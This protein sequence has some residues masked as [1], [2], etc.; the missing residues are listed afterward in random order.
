MTQGS[1]KG[2][3]LGCQR[4]KETTLH[5]KR[6]Q[7]GN[8][9]DLT[10]A[11]EEAGRSKSSKFSKPVQAGLRENVWS[12]FPRVV[13]SFKKKKKPQAENVIQRDPELTVPPRQPTASRITNSARQIRPAPQRVPTK[14]IPRDWVHNQKSHDIHKNRKT[15]YHE[16]K[17]AETQRN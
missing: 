12:K 3:Y 1:P 6:R 14:R 5:Y 11:L 16:E 15:K 2:L 9:P 10:L 8:W 7:R 4:E 13:W 17:P